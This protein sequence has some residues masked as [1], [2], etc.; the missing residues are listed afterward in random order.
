MGSSLLGLL[1]ATIGAPG[2]AGL[3]RG[4]GYDCSR[5]HVLLGV[6]RIDV[7]DSDDPNLLKIEAGD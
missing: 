5:V 3:A 1:V 7:S 4:V 6:V 2:T